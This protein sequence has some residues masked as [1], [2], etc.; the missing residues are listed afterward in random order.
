MCLI[1][2][3]TIYPINSIFIIFYVK[4]ILRSKVLYFFFHVLSIITIYFSYNQNVQIRMYVL[5][6][7]F[8]LSNNQLQSVFYSKCVRDMV[9]YLYTYLN[10]SHY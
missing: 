4:Q 1:T 7:E 2:L 6:N 3:Y 9:L 10:T 8:S 5:L